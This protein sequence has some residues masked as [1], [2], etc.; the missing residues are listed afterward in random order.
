MAFGSLAHEVDMHVCLFFLLSTNLYFRSVCV[1]NTT[2]WMYQ[3]LSVTQW[4]G[5]QFL[6]SKYCIFLTG[7]IMFLFFILKQFYI[8]L[9]PHILY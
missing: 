1:H 7:V 6:S 5:K 4:C 8:K 9:E 3:S 2:T